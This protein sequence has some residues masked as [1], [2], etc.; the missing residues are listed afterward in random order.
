MTPREKAEIVA[1]DL[2]GTCHSL[3]TV[4]ERNDWLGED[5][6]L[7]FCYALDDQVF[8]CALCGWWDEAGAAIDQGNDLVCPDCAEDE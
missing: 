1:D 6:N 7:D 2:R 4:L 3:E 8:C 5:N